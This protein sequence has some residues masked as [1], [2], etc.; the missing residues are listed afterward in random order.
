MIKGPVTTQFGSTHETEIEDDPNV[1]RLVVKIESAI[2]G[3]YTGTLAHVNACI[4]NVYAI[5]DLV[6]TPTGSWDLYLK[7]EIGNTY[8]SNTAVGSPLAGAVFKAAAG[9]LRIIGNIMGDAK[10]ATIV[11]TFIG[12]QAGLVS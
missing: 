9:P 4:A 5:D 12:V 11:I 1:S 3:T 6:A 8:Y 10:R 2:G 7:D